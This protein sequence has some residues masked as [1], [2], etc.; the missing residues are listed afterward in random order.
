M[1]NRT[2]ASIVAKM[3]A[4]PPKETPYE[5]GRRKRG[6]PGGAPKIED[7]V[8]LDALRDVL[9]RGKTRADVARRLNISPATLGQWLDG[10]NRPKLLMQVEKEA[11]RA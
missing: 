8:V 6:R 10:T 5:C 9:I 3:P 4:D 1:M 7:A 11:K 2:L